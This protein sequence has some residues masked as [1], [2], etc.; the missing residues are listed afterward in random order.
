MTTE[1]RGLDI[2]DRY[3][4]SLE[5]LRDGDEL[6]IFAESLDL[7]LFS[8]LIFLSDGRVDIN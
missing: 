2:L 7:S 6:K 4:E 1:E 3:L 8:R 5:E